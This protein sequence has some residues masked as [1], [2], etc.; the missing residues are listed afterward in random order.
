MSIHPCSKCGMLRARHGDKLCSV[1]GLVAELKREHAAGDHDPEAR[2]A[3]CV[4]CMRPLRAHRQ[5]QVSRRL[6]AAATPY[7]GHG[8]LYRELQAASESREDLSIVGPSLHATQRHSHCD[9]EPTKA[10][11]AKCRAQRR[12]AAG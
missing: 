9:H 10:A 5:R 8:E 1:C 6:I 7:A 11:R 12:N 4:D 3:S 2:N